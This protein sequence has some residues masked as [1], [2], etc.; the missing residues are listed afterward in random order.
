[1]MFNRQHTKH[2]L[3]LISNVPRSSAYTDFSAFQN[4]INIVWSRLVYASLGDRADKQLLE[5]ANSTYDVL[6]YFIA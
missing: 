5:A 2:N 3:T 6:E 1:M 4:D